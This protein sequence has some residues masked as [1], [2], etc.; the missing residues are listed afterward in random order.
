MKKSTKNWA[1]STNRAVLPEA[2]RSLGDLMHSFS[3]LLQAFENAASCG[4]A[5]A[6]ARTRDVLMEGH[7]DLLGQIFTDQTAAIGLAAPSRYLLGFGIAL[8]DANND[9]F[10]DLITANGHVNDMRPRFAYAMPALLMAGTASGRL[11]DVT[12]SSGDALQVPRLGRALAEGDLDNDGRGDVLIVAQDGPIAFLHNQT[13]AG[14]SVTFR[15][16]GTRSN[17]DGVGA[18]LTLETGG[19][20]RT[21]QR[22]GGGSFQSAGD[23]RLHFGLGSATQLKTVEVHWPSGQVDRFSNLAADRGY[24]LREGDPE[25]LVLP[26]PGH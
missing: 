8:F 26:G 2:E 7:A 1:S 3:D 20:R 25:A 4:D 11:V 17:R 6:V 16:E 9:G 23:P 22:V 21:A 14:H 15:L 10:L 12:G 18:K 13:D 5:M 24:R 19:L